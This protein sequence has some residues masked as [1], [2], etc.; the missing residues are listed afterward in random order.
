VLRS[1]RELRGEAEAAFVDDL[2]K[3]AR[4]LARHVV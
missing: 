3:V 2:K 1:P 4:Y